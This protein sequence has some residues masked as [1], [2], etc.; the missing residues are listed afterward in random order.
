MK[1]KNNEEWTD[2]YDSDQEEK[3]NP[4]EKQSDD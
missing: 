2:H 4:D 3:E 1:E